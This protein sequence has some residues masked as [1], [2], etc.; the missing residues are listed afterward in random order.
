MKKLRK[1][2]VSGLLAVLPF[3]LTYEI[4]TFLFV[5]V[6]SFLPKFIT[7]GVLLIDFF[8]HL[9]CAGFA[10]L[11]L[12]MVTR[13]LVG[14]RVLLVIST[15][16]SNIPV[17]KVIY[18][19]LHKLFHRFSNKSP[20]EFEQPVLV[21]YPRKGCYSI[22]F[23]CSSEALPH[24]SPSEVGDQCHIY[25]P[26]TPWQGTGFFITLPKNEVQVLDNISREKAVAY[27]LS[28]GILS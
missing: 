19:F 23:I 18:A 16:Y 3:Y 12:G 6:A 13:Q 25:M 5:L 17:V 9:S 27:L 22:G 8:I 26:Y 4:M 15:F 20:E 11:I 7:T 14:K 1:A 28:G 21:E 2:V 24:E 10:L